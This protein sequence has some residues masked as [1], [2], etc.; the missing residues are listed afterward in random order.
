MKRYGNKIIAEVGQVLNNGNGRAFFFEYEEGVE[1]TNEK[2]DDSVVSIGDGYIIGNKIYLTKDKANKKC[3][4]NMLW[5]NDDQ[6]AIIL[7]REQSESKQDMYD[8]MQGWRKFFDVLL[9]KM[10]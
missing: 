6:I 8:F 5:S 9:D 2:L 4:V 7:N 3:L 1:Y 10:K